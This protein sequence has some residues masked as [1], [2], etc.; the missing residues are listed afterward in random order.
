[1]TVKSCHNRLAGKPQAQVREG[2][3][4]YRRL[5]V[6]RRNVA[7]LSPFYWFV[8]KPEITTR[9][10]APV[11]RSWGPGRHPNRRLPLGGWPRSLA[12]GD[13]G[14]TQTEDC[15]SVNNIETAGRTTG[16]LDPSYDQYFQGR[17]LSI[18]TILDKL[19]IFCYFVLMPTVS[20]TYAKQNFAAMLDAAQHEPV[21]IQR[22]GAGGPGPSQL[23]TGETPKPEITSQ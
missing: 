19:Y 6:S 22:H 20:A 11:P 14:D 3:L 8:A 17:L 4:A 15:L 18:L 16:D 10:V 7:P 12:I 1:M 2:R 23:G 13:R 5:T 9:R 21:L